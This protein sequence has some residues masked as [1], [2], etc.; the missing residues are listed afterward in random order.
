MFAN[1]NRVQYTWN[2]RVDKSTIMTL[3]N[4]SPFSVLPVKL[5]GVT[6]T[7]VEEA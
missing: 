2:P 7:K 5:L 6:E 1:K 3:H 4:V